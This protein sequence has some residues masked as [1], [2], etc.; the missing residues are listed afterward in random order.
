MKKLFLITFAVLCLTVLS[1]GGSSSGTA[2][3]GSGGNP[4]VSGNGTVTYY[5]IEGGCWNI[6]AD[7]G[8]V[9]TPTNLSQAFRVDGLRVY[10][11]LTVRNDLGGIPCGGTYVTLDKI[12][13]LGQ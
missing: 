7:D 8:S 2:S 9:Y 3:S 11:E 6:V 5:S 10:F 12:Q 13:A 4:T 1:C